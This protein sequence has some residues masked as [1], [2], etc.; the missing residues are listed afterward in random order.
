MSTDVRELIDLLIAQDR[1]TNLQTFIFGIL[2]V[3]QTELIE[4]I[5]QLEK[6]ASITEAEGINLDLFGV[7]LQLVRPGVPN[8][9]GIYFGFDGYRRIFILP[10]KTK[11]GYSISWLSND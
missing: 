8:E 5:E 7:R 11:L 4:P 2:D 1:G 10:K 9:D 6:Q 3:I